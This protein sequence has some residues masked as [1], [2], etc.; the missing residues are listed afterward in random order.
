[1]VPTKRGYRIR[2]KKET[3]LTLRD[4]QRYS[5]EEA[6][7]K[8]G[9]SHGT[10]WS[11]LTD[12]G[13]ASWRLDHVALKASAWKRSG[14]YHYK[15]NGGRRRCMGYLQV[16]V[17]GHPYATRN[18]YVM[19]HRWKM[20]QKIG[21]YLRDDEIVHH[22]NGIPTDNR[23]GNLKLMVRHEHSRQHRLDE[24]KRGVDRFAGHR[25]HFHK[26]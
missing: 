9:I 3:V 12:W 8:L 1:M 14:K 20:E 5:I 26:P 15:W 10:L 2:V 21:R 22:K 4:S 16:M 6:S 23:M 18:G 13:I 11:R 19:E 17:K 24:L 25:G 7:Q